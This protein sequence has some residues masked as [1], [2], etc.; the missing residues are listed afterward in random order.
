MSLRNYRQAQ[1][2]ILAGSSIIPEGHKKKL[3]ATMAM[4]L[5]HLMADF[6]SKIAV[7]VLL[8]RRG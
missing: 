4:S 7:N 6:L 5:G 2:L 1:Y 8:G 3:R